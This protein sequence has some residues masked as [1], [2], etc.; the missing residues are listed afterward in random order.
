[1]GTIELRADEAAIEEEAG[2]DIRLQGNV[3]ARVVAAER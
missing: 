1:V 3:V 2:G